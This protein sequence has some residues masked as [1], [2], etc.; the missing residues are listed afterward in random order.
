MR[1]ED[2]IRALAHDSASRS[3]SV[4]RRLVTRA[5]VGVLAALCVFA[6]FLTPRPDLSVVIVTPRVA[7]KFLI[8]LALVGA[9]GALTLRAMRPEA[10]SSLWSVLIPVLALLAVGVA[11][12]LISSPPAAWRP[13]LIGSNALA[14]LALVPLLSLLP[15]GSIL[16]ALRYGAPSQPRFAGTIAGLLAGGIGSA[17][18]ALHCPDDSPLFVAAWY[19]LSITVIS[20]LG[21]ALGARWLRW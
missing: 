5:L 18:Y 20:V 16:A 9:A 19:G 12:E 11:A 17:L 2:L 13:L 10:R 14:C 15:L 8:T 7:F 3:E 21:A 1:T 6:L 4:A